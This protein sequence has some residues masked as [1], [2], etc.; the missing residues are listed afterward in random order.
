MWLKTP[1]RIENV[2]WEG[3]LVPAT[4]DA[5]RTL[6]RQWSLFGV[7]ADP[8]KAIASVKILTIGQPDT[9]KITD[10]YKPGTTPYPMQAKLA[11]ADFYAVRLAC[12][13]RV[14]PKEVEVDWGRFSVR[15]LPDAEGRQPV[16]F[17]LHPLMVTQDIKHSV[18]VTLS[19]TLKFQ[20]LEAEAGGAEFGWEYTELQATI[21][22]SGGNEPES[23]WDYSIAKGI[24]TVQG[25]KWMHMLVKAPRGMPKAEVAL[26]LAADLKVRGGDLPVLLP[27]KGA[28]EPLRA[29]LWG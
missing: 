10:F 16:A 11:E 8:K 18:K 17:D 13:F 24:T 4:E 1:D 9:W 27:S 29:K 19:P 22:A 25:T 14:K 5:V 3:A 28:A 7:K 20:Q 26:D 21:S 23:S 6:E 15:L 12:S 2:L